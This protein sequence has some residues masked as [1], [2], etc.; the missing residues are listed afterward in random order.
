MRAKNEKEGHPRKTQYVIRMADRKY[1]GKK[2]VFPAE[3]KDMQ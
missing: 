2:T 3:E 1:G